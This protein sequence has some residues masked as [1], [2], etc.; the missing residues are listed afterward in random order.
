VQIK[1]VNIII[2]NYNGKDLLAK[3]LPSVIEAGDLSRHECKVSVIDNKSSD[4]SVE[5]LRSDFPGVDIFVAKEN[6]VLCSFNEVVRSVTEE[7]VIFLNNDIGLDPGFVDPL[8]SHFGNDGILFAAPKECSPD[9]EFRGGVNRGVF[10]FGFFRNLVKEGSEDTCQYSMAVHGGAFDRKKFNELGGYDDMYLPG[11][12]EDLDLC[13]RGWKRGWYGLYEP[14]SVMFHEGCASFNKTYGHDRKL[15]IVHRNT[16]LFF[17]KN[18]T[19]FR[20]IF[21]H[22]L[23]IVPRLVLSLVTG[24]LSLVLGF[25]QALKRIG[26]ALKG[27][28]DVRGTFTLTDEEVLRRIESGF[29]GIEEEKITQEEVLSANV[30]YH[31]KIAARYE[32]DASTRLLFEESPNS[33]RRIEGVM[34]YLEEETAGEKFL[35]IGCGTGNVLSRAAKRFKEAVGIDASA[36]MLK[37]SEAKGLNVVQGDAL[38]LP[39]PAGTFDAVSAFSVVHHFLR[40]GDILKEAYRVL[41]DGGYLYTDWDPNAKAASLFDAGSQSK[42]FTFI[43][44]FYMS[45]KRKVRSLPENVRSE[46]DELEQLANIAEYHHKKGLDAGKISSELE[47]IGFKD[48]KVYFHNNTDDLF[49][50]ERLN[51]WEMTKITARRALNYDLGVPRPENICSQFAIL[52]RK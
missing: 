44:G 12:V 51:P 17:W 5:F 30:E 37:I 3:Y 19:S 47:H 2:L 34:K 35:D 14:R 23:F 25:F 13:Y 29:T 4:G 45:V 24:R 46:S 49:R 6:R 1:K 40:P 11:Y 7:I 21:L 48:V 20:Q 42:L 10:K 32:K 38:A 31:N 52:A 18:V 41:K 27:R 50:P 26:R 9:G 39:W 36:E 33:G 22:V 28:R 43:H 15:T 8:I 16:F